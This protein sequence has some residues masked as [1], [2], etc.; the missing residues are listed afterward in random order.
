MECFSGEKCRMRM[1]TRKLWGPDAECVS[2]GSGRG[3]IK[4]ARGAV[5]CYGRLEFAL[6]CP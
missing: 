6:L 5:I 1:S 2:R 4:S 3:S